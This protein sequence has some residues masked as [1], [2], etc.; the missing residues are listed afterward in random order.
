MSRFCSGSNSGGAHVRGFRSFSTLARL[1]LDL[2][3]VLQGFE[4]FPSD[5][6]EMDEEIVPSIVGS[7]ESITL[8]ITEPLNGTDRQLT[9]LTLY[10]GTKISW[11][12]V[13]FTRNPGLQAAGQSYRTRLETSYAPLPVSGGAVASARRVPILPTENG[14]LSCPRASLAAHRGPKMAQKRLEM[15]QKPP[16]ARR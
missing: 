7:N 16:S 10:C 6:G 12:L 13:S 15:C 11:P 14:L 9:L 3:A 4:S 8:L 1:V 5:I 2:L